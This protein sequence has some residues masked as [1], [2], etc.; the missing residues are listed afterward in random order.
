MVPVADTSAVIPPGSAQVSEVSG[1]YRVGDA[2]A[3]GLHTRK[4]RP[5]GAG[6]TGIR[7]L[8]ADLVASWHG[9]PFHVPSLGD[10][11]AA[12]RPQD[13]EDSAAGIEDDLP[14]IRPGEGDLSVG[15]THEAGTALPLGLTGSIGQQAPG[16]AAGSH[17]LCDGALCIH[18]GRVPQDIHR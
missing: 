2:P 11:V 14:V 13:T 7:G 12:I 15:C 10:E 3:G 1:A 17:G 5:D 4:V 16:D 18:R 8:Q 9:A 6:A